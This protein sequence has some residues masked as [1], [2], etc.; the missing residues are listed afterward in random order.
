MLDFN[1]TFPTRV[2]FGK[3]ALSR[4]NEVWDTGYKKVLVVCGGSSVHK[5]GILDKVLAALDSRGCSCRVFD[6]VRN[7]PDL[8]VIEDACNLCSDFVPD[9]VIGLGGGSAMDSAKAVALG[10]SCNIDTFWQDVFI[11]GKKIAKAVPVATIPTI[12]ASGSEIGASF[13]LT[14]NATHEKLIATYDCVRPV[15]AIMD[16]TF[17]S[18]LPTYLTELGICDMFSHAMERFFSSDGRDGLA[19]ALLSSLM[20][21]IISYGNRIASGEDGYDLRASIMWA[22]SLAHCDFLDRG[23]GWGDWGCHMLEHRLSADFDIAHAEGLAAIIP[24]WMRT[25]SKRDPDRFA[26]FASSVLGVHKGTNADELAN[27][28]FN[29]MRTVFSSWG[30]PVEIHRNGFDISYCRKA[31]EM[32]SSGPYPPGGTFPLSVEEIF[33]I[34]VAVGGDHGQ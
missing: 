32:F 17:T 24:A 27:V 13:V 5:F 33:S 22:G 2:V 19:Q 4:L 3:D 16:P 15:F 28:L 18:T 21:T 29:S 9:L 12:A 20:K 34:F 14:N 8:K 23:S 26:A 30:L 10:V 6:K 1:L 25:V 7:N 11:S 31:A